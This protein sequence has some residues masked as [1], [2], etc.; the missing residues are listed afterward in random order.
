MRMSNSSVNSNE[1]L[2]I[3]DMSSKNNNANFQNSDQF[4]CTNASSQQQQHQQSQQSSTTSSTHGL[5]PRKRA[6]TFHGSASLTVAAAL[7]NINLSSLGPFCTSPTPTKDSSNSSNRVSRAQSPAPGA[8][9]NRSKFC[10]TIRIK[11]QLKTFLT[12]FLILSH[13]S[14]DLFDLTKTICDCLSYIESSKNIF[15]TSLIY[16]SEFFLFSLNKIV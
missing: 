3:V 15:E 12:I 7:N 13:V 2:A 5:M 10:N 14:F 6:D 4:S 11:F 9:D 8:S 1:K 16:E